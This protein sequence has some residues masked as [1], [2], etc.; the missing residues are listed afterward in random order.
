VKTV[1]LIPGPSTIDSLI[2]PASLTILSAIK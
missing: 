1:I 2:T